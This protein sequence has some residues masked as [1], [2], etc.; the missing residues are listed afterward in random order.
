MLNLGVRTTI[1]I[2][3]AIMHTFLVDSVKKSARKQLYGLH[4]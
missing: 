1:L 4:V 3:N 2:N